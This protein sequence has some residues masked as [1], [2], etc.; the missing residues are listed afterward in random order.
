MTQAQ[1]FMADAQRAI[2]LHSWADGTLNSRPKVGLL[3]GKL[4]RALARV[5]YGGKLLTRKGGTQGVYQ[6]PDLSCVQIGPFKQW[7]R[8]VELPDGLS[9]DDAWLM[10]QRAAEIEAAQ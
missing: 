5:K 6:F 9:P 8:V 7:L 2:D 1:E 10:A 4:A 3:A